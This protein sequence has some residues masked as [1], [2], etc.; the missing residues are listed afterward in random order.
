MPQ[1]IGIPMGT[2]CS[3]FLANLML[4][5]YEFEHFSDEVSRMEPWHLHQKDK[6]FKLSLCTRY[7]DDLWN[8]L[9]SKEPFQKVTKKMYPSWLKLGDPEY[10]GTHVHY[11]DMTI[12]QTMAEHTVE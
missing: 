1:S 10:E 7:I 6:L 8:P 11:L 9:M 4:F 5:M 3:P 12:S 2:S